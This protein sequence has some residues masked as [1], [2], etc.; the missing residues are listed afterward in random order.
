VFNSLKSKITKQNL[1]KSKKSM[2][3]T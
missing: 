1:L 2:T 3:R